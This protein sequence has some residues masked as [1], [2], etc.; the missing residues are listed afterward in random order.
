[1]PR[2][3]KG[4]ATPLLTDEYLGGATSTQLAAK[5]DMTHAA[6]C[7]RLRRA[8]VAIR[9]ARRRTIYDKREQAA[10][11]V[12]A[13]RAGEPMAL[14]GARLGVG[15]S[16]VCRA[17][18]SAGAT[19]RPHGLRRRTVSVPTG[20]ELGYLAGLFDGEGN[21]QMRYKA[22]GSLA[23]KIAIY[24]TTTGVMEWLTR[25]VGGVVRWDHA[26]TRRRGWLPIGSWCIYRAQDVAILLLAMLPHLI[27]KRD[28]ATKAL[29]VF[30][31]R[32]HL[33]TPRQQ[34]PNQ[35]K[36]SSAATTE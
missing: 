24:S 14:I 29:G 32:L 35:R 25:N 4:V 3:R 19:T 30:R 5:Y 26:R 6:V 21:L 12:A 13:Y 36:A 1:M 17:I 33:T 8:G 10:S 9:P 7:R 22:A 15:R 28:A 20:I 27:V 16:T 31:T 18:R 23:C 11:M 34:L 2:H